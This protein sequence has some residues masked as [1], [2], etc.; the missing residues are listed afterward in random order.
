M[1]GPQ[2]LLFF[3]SGDEHVLGLSI[4]AYSN[5]LRIENG[6][7]RQPMEGG[8]YFATQAVARAGRWPYQPVTPEEAVEAVNRRTGAK[9]SEVPELVLRA[10]WHPLLALWRVTLDRPVPVVHKQH[11]GANGP[12]VE[13]RELYVGPGE[14]L[15][16]AAEDGPESMSVFAERHPFRSGEPPVQLGLHRRG[17]L[18]LRFDEVIPDTEV[19]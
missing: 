1:F 8:S 19:R 16:V 18:P 7:I 9:A 4:A 12:P 17:N 6:T 5:D 15:L 14:V 11:S 2:Y 3:D 10:G 13:V